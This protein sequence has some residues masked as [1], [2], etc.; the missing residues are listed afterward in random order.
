M[1]TVQEPVSQPTDGVHRTFSFKLGPF[2]FKVAETPGEL[3]QVHR[4]NY[5]TFVREIP[6]HHD[7]GSGCLVDK[8][9]DKNQYFIALRDERVIG[10]V[11]AHDR[12]PYSVSDRLPDPGILE[13][14]ERPLEVRLLAIESEHRSGMVFAGLLGGLWEHAHAQGYTHVLISGIADRRSMYEQM[15]FKPLGPAVQS[16]QAEFIP[17]VVDLADLPANVVRDLRRFRRRPAR[18]TRPAVCLLPGPV[19]IAPE[20]RE[21]LACPPIYHRGRAFI[22]HFERVRATLSAMT[23]G[24]DVA[25]LCGTGTLANDTVA[26]TLAADPTVQEGL[27]LINGEFGRRLGEQARRFGLRFQK[28]AWPWGRGWDLDQVA[29]L[30]RGHPEINWIW[31]VHLESSTG[32]LNDLDG[33]LRLAR[34]RDVRVCADCVSSLGAVPLDYP[35]LYLAS[36]ASGKS[37]GALAGLAM[38]FSAPGKLADLP[39]EGLPSYLDLP[40]TLATAGPRFTFSSPLLLALERALETYATPEAARVRYLHYEEL[41]RHVRGQLRAAGLVPLADEAAAA[42]VITTLAPPRGESP[43]AFHDRCLDWGFEIASESQY[44]KDRRLVQMAIM[45]AI[46]PADLEPLFQHLRRYSAAAG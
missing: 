11:S 28:L 2:T 37:L 26:A 32:V 40:S 19:Q 29:G 38:V 7:P 18:S 12:P 22:D 14:F 45:G 39:A 10:M 27:L 1:S 36:G 24:M 33:L 44:L 4:L 21:A 41:G 9:H 31:C 30:L 23:G 46:A 34:V 17:M 35:D 42:P 43:E 20:V 25:L 3:E 6:Q 13:R 16:G 8:F 15:G 5:K